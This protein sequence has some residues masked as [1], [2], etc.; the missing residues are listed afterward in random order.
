MPAG[1]GPDAS[2]TERLKHLI[3]TYGWYALGVYTILTVVDFGIAF[4]GINVIGAEKVSRVE[5]AV[6]EYVV[7]FIYTSPPEPGKQEVEKVPQDGSREGLVAM[8]V[9]AY[10][11]HKTL[12]LPF[13][14][15]LTAVLTPRLVGWL[16]KRG[17]AGGEGT[18]RA[19]REFGQR[20]RQGRG[21]D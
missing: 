1:P 6:K 13:R 16:T 7:S 14:V 11:V 17:W 8:L 9:L 15:G 5:R 19:A 12:F 3:K 20:V 2:L 21:Q 4:A 18:K 10:A